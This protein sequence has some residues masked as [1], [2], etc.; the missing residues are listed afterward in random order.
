MTKSNTLKKN[1]L[2]LF[3]LIGILAGLRAQA[4]R[5]GEF[6]RYRIHYFFLNAGYATLSLHESQMN[7]KHVFH[8]VGL[9]K[10]SVLSSLVMDVNDRYETYFDDR[11]R[12]LRFIRHIRE[13]NYHKNVEF[14]FHHDQNLLQVI[15]HLRNNVKSYHVPPGIQDMLSVYYK[16]RNVDTS[17]LKK[18]D[19]IS[20]DLFFDNEIYHFKMKI[21]GRQTI[22]TKFGKIRTIVLRPYVQAE[23][24]FKEQESLTVWVT[25]D[26][27]KIPVR[28]RAKLLVGS[29]K[30]DLVEYRGLK[31][32]IHFE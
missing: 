14:I 2:S 9:G 15:D 20:E 31:Y 16:L 32:P 29:I 3:L 12:P 7:G 8:A 5:G 13:G 22:N 6:L 26:E 30:A 4:Y 24:V 27:N 17:K 21:L 23:R 25:D 11:N 18:G 10:T 28:I 1:F 19:F